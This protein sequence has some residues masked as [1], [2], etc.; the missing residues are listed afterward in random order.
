MATIQERRRYP[1]ATYVGRVEVRAGRTAYAATPQNLSLG[2]MSVQIDQELEL[3]CLVD[4]HLHPQPGQPAIVCQ[5]R[6]NWVTARMD[7]RRTPPIPHDVG[8]EFLNLSPGARRRLLQFVDDLRSREAAPTYGP[9]LKPATIHGRS[10]TPF[11][12]VDTHPSGDWELLVYEGE[13]CCYEHRYETTE[14]ALRGWHAFQDEV[15]KARVH[16]ATAHAR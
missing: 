10:L 8:I 11:L 1:R 6:V 7:L 3:R 9:H 15:A 13:H 2:G 5:G 16:R 4:I 14:Q 12:R